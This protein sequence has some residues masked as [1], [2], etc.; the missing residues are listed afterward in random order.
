MRGELYD[1]TPEGLAAVDKGEEVGSPGNFRRMIEVVKADGDTI[2]ALAFFKDPRLARPRHSGYL[3]DYH[4]GRFL[5]KGQ[6][7]VSQPRLKLLSE[8]SPGRG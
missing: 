1:V 6:R 3:A 2:S 8:S 5:P 4:D 7:P